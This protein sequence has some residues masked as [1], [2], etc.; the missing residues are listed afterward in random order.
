MTA[1]S[2]ITSW[3][4]AT[5]WASSPWTLIITRSGWRMYGSPSLSLCP[6]WACAA[7]CNAFS[8]VATLVLPSFVNLARYRD[9]P[10]NPVRPHHPR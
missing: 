6:S 7:I 2:S 10:D 1:V 4:T 9:R 8:M 5:I 3:R